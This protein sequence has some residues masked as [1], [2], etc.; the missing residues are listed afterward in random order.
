MSRHRGWK[1]EHIYC[2]K[3]YRKIR[4]RRE[5]E[6]P[7]WNDLNAKL[8]SFYFIYIT[9]VNDGF[10][11]LIRVIFWEDW[12]IAKWLG[13]CRR[14]GS[15]EMGRPF[16]SHSFKKRLLLTYSLPYFMFVLSTVN[17]ILL[18]WTVIVNWYFRAKV[19]KTALVCVCRNEV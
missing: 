12:V 14:G 13:G 3:N 7:Y 6:S 19:M 16:F 5:G 18:T 11:D 10:Y 8:R 17:C 4:L 9:L 2:R 1:I 15:R